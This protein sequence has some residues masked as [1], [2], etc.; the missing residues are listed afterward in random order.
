[1]RG[2]LEQPGLAGANFYLRPDGQVV[3]PTVPGVPLPPR[4]RVI[5]ETYTIFSE[6]QT[7]LVFNVGFAF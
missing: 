1:M 5:P 6:H 2:Y 7:G 3:A 4:G